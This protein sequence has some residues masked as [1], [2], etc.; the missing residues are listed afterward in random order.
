MSRY[1]ELNTNIKNGSLWTS[2]D[3]Y[4]N[5]KIDMD[6]FSVDEQKKLLGELKEVLVNKYYSEHESTEKNV[7]IR[8]SN[9]SS[10]IVSNFFKLEDAQNTRFN[11]T[12]WWDSCEDDD[13]GYIIHLSGCAWYSTCEMSICDLLI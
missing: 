8:I 11:E 1:E 10:S 9:I 13:T 2:D 5:M 3:E 6:G 7:R 4:F 12:N